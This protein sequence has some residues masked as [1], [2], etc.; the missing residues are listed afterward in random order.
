MMFPRLAA[1]AILVAGVTFAGVA[2]RQ[3]FAQSPLPEQPRFSPFA[4]DGGQQ[5]GAAGGFNFG[6]GQTDKEM[7]KLLNDEARHEQ[8]ASRLVQQYSHTED[9]GERTKI[10]SK[11][12]D[13]LDKQFDLQQKR[14]DL[15]IKR[16]EAQ[17]KKVRELMQKRS[18]A[19]EKIVK[20]RL[21]QLLQEADG[22]GWTPPPGPH[23]PQY[24]GFFAPRPTPKID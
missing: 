4:L 13:V 23:V 2:L 22:L 19:R 1:A 3:A 6:Y 16:I 21:D 10:R 24:G 14:R 12:S 8:E 15:E 18:D 9:D 17:L 5:Y 20:R 7:A 11:L